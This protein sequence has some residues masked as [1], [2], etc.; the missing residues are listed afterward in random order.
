MKQSFL[1]LG[2]SLLA[3]ATLFTG[4]KES[5]GVETVVP[6]V[7]ITADANF[8]SDNTANLTLTLSEATTE[9]VTVTLGDAEVQSGK[10][11]VTAIYSKTVTIKAGET[12]AKVTVQA[13]T[14][15]LESGEYQAAIQIVSAEGAEVAET[16][17]V[18][19]GFDYVERPNVELYSE[20]TDVPVTREFNLL[21][22]LS[23]A[24]TDPVTVTLADGADN[25]VPVTYEK[26]VSIPAGETEVKVPVTVNTDGLE[27]GIY[28]VVIDL[29]A[30]ENAVVGTAKSASVNLTYP[31]SASVTI[32]GVFD[33]WDAIECS[34]FT[35]P[36]G[37]VVYP[38]VKTLK[39]A[40]NSKDV[41]IYFDFAK[42]EDYGYMPLETNTIPFNFYI[43]KDGDP[44]TGAWVGTI[45]NNTAG[46]PFTPMG[47]DYYFESGLHNP[48]NEEQPFSNF[49]SATIYWAECHK[50][51]GYFWSADVTLH[52]LAS[53]GP[54]YTGED[55]YG[56]VV[57]GDDG[58]SR[59]E[60]KLS[61]TYFGITGTKF[62]F[63]L[64]LMETD[65]SW[66]AMG[67]LPQ[68]NAASDGSFVPT[69]MA[70]VTIPEYEAPVETE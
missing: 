10:T 25:Q 49:T 19:I 9:E 47:F 38:V 28:K 48:G 36:E 42:P 13:E 61:R 24:Y 33:E 59:A 70:T 34:T 60:V 43:D 45:D 17:V 6:T 16:P 5:A 37:D 31:F 7:S 18:Y 12:S 23:A 11:K 22:R 27:A 50:D 58:I 35:L 64:K 20:V 8:A 3:V 67:L 46:E 29:T 65:N 54:I 56:M 68:V 15:G 30:A 57:T 69:D 41:Y 62:R 39:I 2:M 21:V 55:V 40:A 4:C 44:A 14:L 63:A 66:A 26:N 52:N 1:T 51:G 53:E 32:D